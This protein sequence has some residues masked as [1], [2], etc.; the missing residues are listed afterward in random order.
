ML[1]L[2]RKM[3]EASVMLQVFVSAESSYVFDKIASGMPPKPESIIRKE[4]QAELRKWQ[5]GWDVLKTQ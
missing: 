5:D 3:R 2:C 4:K 1:K